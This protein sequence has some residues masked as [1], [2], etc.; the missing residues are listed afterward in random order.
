MARSFLLPRREESLP[1]QGVFTT[2]HARPARTRWGKDDRNTW[3]VRSMC[4]Y[5]LISPLSVLSYQ[6]SV[7]CRLLEII[8]I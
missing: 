2:Y 7:H 6:R 3:W 1:L 5:L 8:G 4:G